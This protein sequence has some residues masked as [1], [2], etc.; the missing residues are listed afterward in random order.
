MKKKLL[1]DMIEL[2]NLGTEIQTMQA[3][4]WFIRFIGPYAMKNKNFV[5]KM[6]KL[7]EQAFSDVDP[8]VQ[9]TA[10]VSLLGPLKISIAL[11]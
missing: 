7:P 11:K 1:P 2:L 9:I 6:L 10:L 5:N 3:W 8:Q 4:G